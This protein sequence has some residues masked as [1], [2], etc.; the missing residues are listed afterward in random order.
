ME[1]EQKRQ[2]ALDE[3]A[4]CETRAAE[5]V[6]EVARLLTAAD[7]QIRQIKGW[8]DYIERLDLTQG[9]WTRPY[10]TVIQGGN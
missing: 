3:I 2:T 4:A 10:L 6:A 7:V 5:I 9:E 1:Y 8:T